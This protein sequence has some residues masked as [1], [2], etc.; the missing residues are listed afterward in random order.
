MDC[1]RKLRTVVVGMG[2]MGVTRYKTLKKHDAFEVV[3]LCDTD[4]AL[5]EGYDEKTYAN[6]RQ[7]LEDEEYDVV[8]SCAYNNVIPDIVCEALDRGA[9]VFSE[10]PPGRTLEDAFRMKHALLRNSG[11]S[12]KFGFNH[13]FHHSVLEAKTL[14]D[15]GILGDVAC[16]RGTYGKAGLVNNPDAWRNN[17]ELSGGG[18][19][20]DQG[21][22]MMDLLRYFLGDFV[23]IH[24]SVD[25]LMKDN[26]LEDNAFAIMKTANGK[27]AMFHSSAT[28]WRHKFCLELIC[29]G[30]VVTLDG[31]I[32]STNSYGEEKLSYYKRD[33]E[34]KTGP[35]GKPCEQTYI[36]EQ[37]RSW[38][39][40]LEEFHDVILN[41]RTHFN[42][43]IDDAIAV[44]SLITQ[45]YQ[46]SGI[47]VHG[48]VYPR[49]A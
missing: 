37:D 18:I 28:Q 46:Q 17:I 38:E 3:A 14:I 49:A 16:A 47:A 41:N 27:T 24:G 36:F 20:L 21:I 48:K 25:N 13:R 33:S 40:E 7:C 32:T 30:G 39:Y 12:L 10:K 22:H 31:L 11:Q 2:R 23:S 19:L 29:S 15:S 8:F 45:V 35:L 26:R 4:P 44:M 5:L 9:H 1:D 42:G 43:N 6:W 34:L